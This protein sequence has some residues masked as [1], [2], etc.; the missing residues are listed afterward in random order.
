MTETER[1]KLLLDLAV[2][3]AELTGHESEIGRDDIEI[4]IDL[5]P[6]RLKQG[7]H[8]VHWEVALALLKAEM[9]K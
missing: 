5:N 4:G 7:S 3:I 9:G 1:L 6:L 8:Q 2:E